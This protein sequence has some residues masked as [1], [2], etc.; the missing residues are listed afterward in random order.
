[1]KCED[2]CCKTY[3]VKISSLDIINMVKHLDITHEDVFNLIL[4]D[5]GYLH[6]KKTNDIACCI[7]YNPENLN[8][9]CMIQDFKPEI[10]ER[11]TCKKC[12][13]KHEE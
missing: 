12:R 8:K 13:F 4:D 10:C 6:F 2:N 3:K 7:F 9:G 1:M 5:E 11:H